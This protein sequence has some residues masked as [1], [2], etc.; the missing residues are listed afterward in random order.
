MEAIA[1]ALSGVR[2]LYGRV[3]D[4]MEAKVWGATF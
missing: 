4:T 1:S 3:L 2:K